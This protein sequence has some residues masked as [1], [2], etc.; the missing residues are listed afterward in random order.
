MPATIKASTSVPFFARFVLNT[1]EPLAAVCGTLI[2]LR[3]PQTFISL[4]LTRGAT[5]GSLEAHALCN[6]LAGLWVVWAFNEAIIMRV[7]D[8]LRLWRLLLLGML[9]SDAAYFYGAAHAVGGFGSLFDVGE[10]TVEE[11]LTTITSSIFLLTRLPLWC[12]ALASRQVRRSGRIKLGTFEA[13]PSGEAV[14]CVDLDAHV[15]HCI[16]QSLTNR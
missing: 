15:S 1:V 4:Y 13:V 14:K 8:D 6:Q 5:R 9:F 2:A 12:W 11:T 10:L 16:I 3:T 7:Y